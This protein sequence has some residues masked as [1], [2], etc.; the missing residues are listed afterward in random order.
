MSVLQMPSLP[1]DASG[2]PV[3]HTGAMDKATDTLMDLV[4]DLPESVYF[5]NRT[6]AEWV[7][8]CVMAAYWRAVREPR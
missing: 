4:N 1:L 8:S 6:D 3:R 7:M 5:L 2:Y